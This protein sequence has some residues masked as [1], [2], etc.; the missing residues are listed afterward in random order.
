MGWLTDFCVD[1]WI[2]AVITWKFLRLNKVGYENV[3][4]FQ[5]G[6]FGGDNLENEEK[7]C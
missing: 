6:G 4:R 5:V 2:L 7:K 3:E 1:W